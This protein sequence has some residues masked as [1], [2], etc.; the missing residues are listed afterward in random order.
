MSYHIAATSAAVMLGSGGYAYIKTGSVPSIIGSAA[1]ATLFGASA[2]ANKST[3]HQFLGHGLG[4]LAG[5]ACLAIGITRYN[6][7]TRKIAPITL[8]ITGA[9]NLPYHLYKAKQWS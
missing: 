3:D 5:L 7:A 4:A 1:I 9:L 8:I 2:Y 6:K